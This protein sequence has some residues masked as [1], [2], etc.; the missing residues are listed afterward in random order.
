MLR[1]L[2]RDR[3]SALDRFM[4]GSSDELRAQLA[5]ALAAGAQGARARLETVIRLAL[6]FWTWERLAEDGYDDADAADLMAGC[7]RG[8]G[9]TAGDSDLTGYWPSSSDFCC[10]LPRP[11]TS[12]GLIGTTRPDSSTRVWGGTFEILTT[13]SPSGTL[14]SAVTAFALPWRPAAIR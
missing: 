8:V 2:Y 12:L 1:N 6:H 13:N 10:P 11:M 5:S 7:R 4:R 14:P 9:W 3:G